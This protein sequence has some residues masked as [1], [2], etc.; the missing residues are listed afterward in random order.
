MK[1]NQYSSKAFAYKTVNVIT[2]SKRCF[3]CVKQAGIKPGKII[4]NRQNTLIIKFRVS[5]FPTGSTQE[6]K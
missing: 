4:I 6:V 3:F 2:F 1:K 5:H